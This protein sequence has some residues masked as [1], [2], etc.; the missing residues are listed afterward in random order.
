LTLEFRGA[1]DTKATLHEGRDFRLRPT[2]CRLRDA[3]FIWRNQH[4]ALG[5]RS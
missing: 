3:F 1:L 5:T 2:V 4:N